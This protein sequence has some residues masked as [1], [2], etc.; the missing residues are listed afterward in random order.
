MLKKIG[1]C[2]KSNFFPFP[3]LQ[4]IH[5]PVK[6]REKKKIPQISH[7]HF[8]LE[9]CQLGFFVFFCDFG[10]AFDCLIIKKINK[11]KKCVFVLVRDFVQMERKKKRGKKRYGVGIEGG[12]KK[13]E[14]RTSSSRSGWQ[15][16]RQRVCQGDG[17]CSQHLLV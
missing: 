8:G 12:E 3:P 1:W 2:S 13:E 11:K 4:T 14:R 5:E 7:G 16:I 10:F 15:S 9:F 6:R 17:A